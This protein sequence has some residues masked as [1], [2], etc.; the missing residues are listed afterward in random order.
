M[1]HNCLNTNNQ[2]VDF[3]NVTVKGERYIFFDS[4]TRE[5]SVN[6][7]GYQGFTAKSLSGAGYAAENGTIMLKKRIA[8]H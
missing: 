8:V 3:D 1:R 4:F 6:D 2:A 7:T 5:N